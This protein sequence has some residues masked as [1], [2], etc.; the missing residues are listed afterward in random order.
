VAESRLLDGEFVVDTVIRAF[1][2]CKENL[3]R[4]RYAKAIN[5]LILGATGIVPPGYGLERDA[6]IRG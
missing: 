6:V 2:R 1:N 4:P 3:A 5:E